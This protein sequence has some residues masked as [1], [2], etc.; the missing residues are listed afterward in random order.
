MRYY[1][2]ELVADRGMEME[3]QVLEIIRELQ[4]SAYE[5]GVSI[6]EI[7]NRFAE[8]HSEEY[9]R[10]ITPHWIGQIVRRKLHLKTEKRHGSYVVAATEG[11]KL[12]RLFERYGISSPRDLGD[13]G[14]FH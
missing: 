6:K 4:Q 14:D 10:K 12:V 2:R 5:P 8:Q 9:E 1:H 13:S 7:T 11:L 3:A